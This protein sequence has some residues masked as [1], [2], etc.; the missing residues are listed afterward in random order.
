M[1]ANRSGRFAPLRRWSIL[2]L[3]LPLAALLFSCQTLKTETAVLMY[4]I[5]SDLESEQ[6]RASADLDEI[7]QAD[8][9]GLPVL[10]Q[11]GGAERWDNPLIRND[12]VQR[13]TVQDGEL[14]ELEALEQVSMAD[15][16]TLS[17]FLRWA[18]SLCPAKRYIV[19]FWNHGGGTALGFGCDEF[20]PND[21]LSLS[22]F[23]QAFESAQLHGALVGFDACLMGTVETAS[24]LSGCADLLLAS[25]ETEPNEGWYY[26]NWLTTLAQQPSMPL[27]TLA[28]TVIDDYASHC[29]EDEY[30][31]SLVD[32][33][34]A[35]TVLPRLSDWLAKGFSDPKTQYK[36]L[37]S[38]R[39]AAL[40]LGDGDFDQIDLL[41]FLSAAGADDNLCTAFEQAVLY[42]RSNC[43]DAHGLAFYA[44]YRLPEYY[45]TLR[46][47][48]S[49]MND[50]LSPLADC[51]DRF[52]SVLAYARSQN[53]SPSIAKQWFGIVL[54]DFSADLTSE[55]WYSSAFAAEGFDEAL[56]VSRLL[57]PTLTKTNSSVTCSLTKNISFVLSSAQLELYADIN[58]KGLLLFG[59]LPAECSSDGASVPFNGQWPSL[60]DGQLVPFYGVSWDDASLLG[61]SNATLNNDKNIRLVIRWTGNTAELLGYQLCP[62]EE[63][64]VSFPTRG[65]SML[66]NGDTLDF[67]CPY[68]RADGYY[69][70]MCYADG[71]VTVGESGLA[72]QLLP[73]D[74]QQSTVLSMKLTDLYQ[75]S[76]WT[77]PLVL[78]E[79]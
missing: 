12:A 24:S 15:T 38:A 41:G 23:R 67:F 52:L 50:A 9:D 34:K 20:F 29:S 10:I 57:Q 17:D 30:T 54:D 79:S 73:L 76:A 37:A 27:E 45:S 58:G 65:L 8:L 31:L 69:D 22:D 7:C 55:D 36:R 28:Q 39:C 16:D 48:L 44:P 66:K 68:T 6:G 47:Q 74:S 4:I 40:E 61:Y 26:T 33:Q 21:T 2:L 63:E 77:E 64:S 5:G 13:F 51:Y 18:K 49:H 14:Q 75:C 53:S 25:E 59:S 70:S 62:D 1:I 56:S 78:S 42:S 19:I 32:T 3:L 35:T 72:L 46:P 11:T 60:D 43:S 71:T